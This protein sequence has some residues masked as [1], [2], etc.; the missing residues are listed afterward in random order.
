[1]SSAISSNAKGVGAYDNK[2]LAHKME[3]FACIFGN[4]G[5]RFAKIRPHFGLISPH[6]PR[7]LDCDVCPPWIRENGEIPWLHMNIPERLVLFGCD[8]GGRPDQKR[9]FWTLRREQV[10]SMPN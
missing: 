9:E 7:H 3:R 4:N 10:S 5:C 2:Q 8:E 1:M 6:K